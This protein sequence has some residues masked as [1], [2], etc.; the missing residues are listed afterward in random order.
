MFDPK[1]TYFPYP[2][3]TDKHYLGVKKDM[4]IVFDKNYPFVDK[5]FKS[6]FMRFLYRVICVIFAFP[7][8]KL[9]TGLKVKGKEILKKYKNVLD[10]GIISICNHIHMWDYLGVMS[11]VF[12]YK[13]HVLTWDKNI[14]GENGNLIRCVGGIPVPVGDPRAS[15]QMVNEA[16]NLVKNGGWLHISAEGSM[17]EFYRPI[18]PFKDGP[19]F[20]SYRTERPILPMAWTYRPLKGLNKLFH[21]FPLLTLNIGEPIY[22]NLNLDKKEGI[23]ELTTRIHQ[24]VCRLAG[25][26]DGE[27]IYEPIFNNSKR[28]DY[29]TKEYG[30]GYKGSW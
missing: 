12:P 7:V 21:H 20:F 1:M 26:K 16:S 14:N 27:N 30:I 18:R 28:I 24:S 15:L 17:W 22:P 19:A 6:K 29:Y 2:I 9:R 25:F 10:K 4:G 8:F 3:D 5:S 13:T 23:K 11:A